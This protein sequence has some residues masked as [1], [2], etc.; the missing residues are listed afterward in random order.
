MPEPVPEPLTSVF[1]VNGTRTSQGPDPGPKALPASEANALIGMKYA[2]YGDKPPGLPDPEPSARP[3]PHVPPV[4][5]AS[6][7]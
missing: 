1:V 6:S 2:V 3:F 4:R 7:N 5:S